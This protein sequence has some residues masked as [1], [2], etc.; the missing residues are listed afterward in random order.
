MLEKKLLKKDIS[1]S[2]VVTKLDYLFL[3]SRYFFMY[4]W[5]LGLLAVMILKYERQ[6]KIRLFIAPP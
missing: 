6:K 5:F 3:L 2:V 1:R 4:T